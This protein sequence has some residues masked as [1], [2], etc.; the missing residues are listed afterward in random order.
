MT[1]DMNP[2]CSERG[3]VL[4]FGALALTMFLGFVG[5]VID[6]G[7]YY[8]ERRQAQNAADN[9]SMAGTRV[10]AAGSSEAAA[11]AAAIEYAVA[12]GFEAAEVTV[13]IPPASGEHAGE[14]SYLEVIIDRSPNTFFIHVILDETNDVGARGVAHYATGDGSGYAMFATGDDCGVPDTLGLPGSNFDVFGP[15]HSNSTIQIN[16]S[17]NAF[18]GP[19][20]HLCDLDESGNNN[21]YNPAAEYGSSEPPPVDYVYADVPCDMEFTEDT[22][23]SSV[24]A[25][26][27]GGD[28]SSGEL[29]PG[30]YCSTGKLV[31]SGS[32]V[33]GNITIVAQGEVN[34]SGSQFTLTP[35]WN[36]VLLFTE[37]SSSSAMDL[38]GSGGDW[39][40]ILFA[41]NGQVKV[42]GSNNQ[43]ISG[44][45]VADAIEASG[46]NWSLTAL[47]YYAGG[48]PAVSLVE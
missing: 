43:S 18:D 4:V 29:I 48:A 14:D 6:S 16:G 37:D 36:D 22:D 19:I 44:S 8:T 32:Q 1:H 26:W 17:N 30:V 2:N 11:T 45:I 27:V 12:N 39:E 7:F 35:Y 33:T 40:W 31:L 25:A 34:V 23:L 41:P 47:D 3:Q 28:S 24:G 9:A 10:L 21:T 13:N 5:L 38:S 42:S 15:I 20:T 46:S